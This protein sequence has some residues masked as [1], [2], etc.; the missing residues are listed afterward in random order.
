MIVADAKGYYEE[1]GLDVELLPG[2]PNVVPLQVVAN[3]GADVGLTSVLELLAARDKDLPLQA[4]AQLDQLSALLLV[5][6]KESGLEKAEDL[7][8]KRIGLW[9]GGDEYEFYA[10]ARQLGNDP[11]ADYQIVN[12]SFTMDQFINGEIDATSAM[13]FDQLLVLESQEGF[14]RDKLNI[15][16]YNQFG[17][18]NPRG[19]VVATETAVSEKAD[20]LARFLRATYRGWEYTFDN[21]ADALDELMKVVPAGDYTRDHQEKSIQEMQRLMLPDGFARTDLGRIDTDTFTR[22]GEVG[23]EYGVIEAAPDDAVY[24]TSIYDA[25]RS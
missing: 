12:Q 5:T 20:A 23:L 8:G 1:E 24:V 2:G 22:A 15:I 14:E 21:Q 11:E 18:V 9:L 19:V 3:G 13:S 4:I 7:E 25:S 10:M 6:T 16:D 17:T